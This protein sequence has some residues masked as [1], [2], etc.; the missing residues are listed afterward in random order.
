MAD[1]DRGRVEAALADAAVNAA[2]LVLADD[3]VVHDRAQ[4][5][6]KG[7]SDLAIVPPDHFG[8]ERAESGQGEPANL[9]R[10]H[11]VY[12]RSGEARYREVVHHRLE[13]PAA[14]CAQLGGYR[15]LGPRGAAI[16]L[17]RDGLAFERSD[18]H[19][20]VPR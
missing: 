2:A 4:Q 13:A 1:A 14:R 12:R 19:L 15:E 8:L 10:V 18:R 5:L 20:Y 9:A 16:F 3:V 11:A 17:R 7:A 6:G